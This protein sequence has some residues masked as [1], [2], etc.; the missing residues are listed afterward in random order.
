MKKIVLL[1]V[2]IF[3]FSNTYAVQRIVSGKV[4]LDNKF[5][6]GNIV[7]TAK[8]SKATV[9][10]NNAGEFSIACEEN[11]ILLFKATPFYI[12]RKSV[13]EKDFLN[14]NM[15]LKKGA[16]DE[17][18]IVDLGFI[19]VEDMKSFTKSLNELDDDYQAYA[20]IYDVI[21][22]KFPYVVIT[23]SYE[24]IVRGKNSLQGNNAALLVVNGTVTNDI[25]YIQPVEIKTINLL[26]G[27][28]AAIY[29]SRGANGVVVIKTK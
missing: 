12:V 27:S 25:S 26:K 19:R 7:V 24:I 6:L 16:V 4:F 8:K 28:N 18:K 17:K 11:D 2:I 14:V 23:D 22:R 15:S 29:G 20:D 5:T 3:A 9:S 1:I 10:T 21:A 13:K